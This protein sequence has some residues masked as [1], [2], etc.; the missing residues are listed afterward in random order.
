[1]AKISAHGAVIGT[2]YLVGDALRFM[3]DGTVLRYR[4][5]RWTIAKSLAPSEVKTAYEEITRKTEESLQKHPAL[6]KYRFFL[7]GL[8]HLNK[9]ARVHAAVTRNPHDPDRVYEDV[10][11]QY[12]YPVVNVSLNDVREL[13]ALWLEV[14]EEKGLR[15]QKVAE[16]A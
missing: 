9:R 14:E 6:R 2:I 16:C 8:F 11:W 5:I 1:M 7:H 3:S 12:A 10:S 13:C 4:G 15:T